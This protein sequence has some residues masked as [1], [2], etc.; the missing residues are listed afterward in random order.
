MTAQPEK[1]LKKWK[2]IGET[3]GWLYAE[4][5]GKGREEEEGRVKR[6]QRLKGRKEEKRNEWDKAGAKLSDIA[7]EILEKKD[8]N[9]DQRDR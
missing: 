2:S 7:S 5:R 4:M 9:C 3:H 1:K 6:T 8:T